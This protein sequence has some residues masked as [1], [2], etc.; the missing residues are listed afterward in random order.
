MSDLPLDC[1]GFGMKNK[2]RYDP[3]HYLSCSAHKRKE[4]TMGHDLLVKVVHQYN[5]LTGG[6][7]NIELMTWTTM[8]VADLICNY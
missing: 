5:Q 2:V 1:H 6:T 3:Y 7:G 4:I 8:M